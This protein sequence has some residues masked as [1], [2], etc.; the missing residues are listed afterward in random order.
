VKVL[1]S[2]H[3]KGGVGKTATTVNLAYLLAEQGARTL[4]WDLDPQGATSFYFRVKPKVK[5]GV[6]GLLERRKAIRRS[7]R[8]TDYE[9][10]DLLPADFSARHLD[11]A[12]DHVGKPR[13]RLRAALRQLRSDYDVVLIDC[14]PSIGL[15]SESVFRAADA[16][17][18]P[19]I[20][21]TL[22][23][24]SLEQ[25][26]T[27]VNQLRHAPEIWPFFSMVDARKSLHREV[28][29]AAPSLPYRF[30][31]ARIP[32]SSHVE[33]MGIRRAPLP[34]YAPTSGAARAYRELL[35]EIAER[36]RE[37]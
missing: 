5:G 17:L 11:V 28:C 33:R 12:L 22:S 30:L 37:D 9:G 2:Y 8:G 24:N 15:A 26:A 19:I 29:D 21:T 23:L 14:P 7:I 25:L 36:V 13:R 32:Y 18:V 34:S 10:L 27:H 6:Q 20:P 16:L 35:D 3:L 31:N 1:A 4:V